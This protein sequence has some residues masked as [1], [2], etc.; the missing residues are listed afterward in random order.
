M[1]RAGDEKP[2]GAHRSKGEN[3][4]KKQM[5]CIGCVDREY[6]DF[7]A[8]DRL[9]VDCERVVSTWGTDGVEGGKIPVEPRATRVISLS[10][11]RKVLMVA[12]SRLEGGRA[13][14][15]RET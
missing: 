9:A 1:V 6:F 14:F 13:A 7:L 15:C 4:N 12:N 2:T 5:A 3:A 10:R 11:D 8:N